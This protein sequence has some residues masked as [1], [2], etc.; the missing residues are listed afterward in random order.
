MQHAGPRI[1][2]VFAEESGFA[3][4]DVDELWR[5]TMRFLDAFPTMVRNTAR[6]RELEAAA[7][8]ELSAAAVLRIGS[9]GRVLVCIPSNA[10]LPLALAVP[11]AYVAAGNDVVVVS[12]SRAARTTAM[13][14]ERLRD[15]LGPRVELRSGGVRNAIAA[16]VE[17]FDLIYFMGG[18]E[19]RIPLATSC[20]A[21]GTH[22][23]YEGSGRGVAVVDALG[24]CA[25]LRACAE[26]VLRAKVFA[27]GQM[28]SSPNVVLCHRDDR[29]AFHAAFD[30]AAAR[31]PLAGSLREL[32]TPAT[33]AYA[34]ACGGGSSSTTFERFA[35]SSHAVLLPCDV[36]ADGV[37]HELF[38][39]LAFLC[40]WDD[41]EA[42]KAA[43]ARLRHRLQ[44][45]LFSRSPAWVASIV[46]A[47][48]FAR[49]CTNVC[50]TD[51]DPALAWGGYGQSGDSLVADHLT[52]AQR[53]FIVEGS[54]S[55]ASDR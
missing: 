7:T 6:R 46:E 35:D 51:Q 36:L 50:P 21:A 32:V 5:A 40:T 27:F 23:V 31:S 37:E 22:L 48:R 25:E 10:P 3:A 26:L 9:W 42:L 11:L 41:P 53:P 47:T 4:A 12:A 14:V 49:Y 45:S 16:G 19:A 8:R 34:D 30:A 38:S 13:I 1:R 39:P 55:I 33:W 24:D 17:A 44:L 15:I 29:E 52:K 54:P 28:C 18:S 43:L 20:A 2:A